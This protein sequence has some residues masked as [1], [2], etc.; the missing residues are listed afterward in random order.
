[1]S[2]RTFSKISEQ[3]S[4]RTSEM[5]VPNENKY[6]LSNNEDTNFSNIKILDIPK[7]CW[8][9]KTTGIMITNDGNRNTTCMDCITVLRKDGIDTKPKI[10]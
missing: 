1:M 10:D 2:Y 7:E 3:P 9:C 6:L 8:N 5:D 4:L